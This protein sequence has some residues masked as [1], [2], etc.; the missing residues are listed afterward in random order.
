MTPNEPTIQ[1]AASRQT[2]R[3][4]HEDTVAPTSEL[5]AKK[6]RLPKTRTPRAINEQRRHQI[7]DAFLACIGRKGLE[8]TTIADVADEAGLQRTLVYHYFKDRESLIDSLIDYLDE[9]KLMHRFSAIVVAEP[10]ERLSLLLDTVFAPSF[11]APTSE[12]TDAFTELVSLG[13]RDE[14]VGVKMH[15][16]WQNSISIFEQ[17]LVEA[18]GARQEDCAV[19]AYAI[20]CLFEHNA[21]MQLLGFGEKENH[22]ARVAC[23]SLI[24]TLMPF[25]GRR[26]G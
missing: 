12:G 8:R 24:S 13:I 10:T 5:D 23:E 19:V 25:S 15:A 2:T 16:M 6:T 26:Q 14:R 9:T 3:A 18:T 17:A 11:F 4:E 21:V 1:N 22:L 20:T 7:L